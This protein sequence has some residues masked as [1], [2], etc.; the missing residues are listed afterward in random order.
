M[1]KNKSLIARIVILACALTFL[2]LPI[3]MLIIYSFNESKMVT[4]WTKASLHWYYELFSDSQIGHAVLISLTVAFMTACASVVIGTLAAFVLVRVRS[5]TGESLFVLLITAPM[6]LPEVIT[7]L[8]AFNALC[9]LRVKSSPGLPTEEYSQSGLPTLHSA[10][11]I[12][13]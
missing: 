11:H 13:P 5:F 10:L 12:P 4:V 6:V 3:L 2:Y 7:G 8:A 9:Y 1:R